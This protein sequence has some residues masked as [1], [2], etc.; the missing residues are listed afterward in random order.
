[1]CPKGMMKMDDLKRAFEEMKDQGE[2][3]QKQKWKEG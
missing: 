2:M 1:M 3:K